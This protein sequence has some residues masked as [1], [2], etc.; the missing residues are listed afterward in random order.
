MPIS[1]IQFTFAPGG[2]FYPDDGFFENFRRELERLAP[3][4]RIQIVDPANWSADELAETSVFMGWPS[5]AML[6]AMPALRWIQLPSAGAD[7]YVGNPRLRDNVALTTAS[8]VFGVAGAEHALALLFA[9]ARGVHFHVA[10]TLENRWRMPESSFEIFES[11]IAVFGLGSIGSETAHRLSCLGAR[12]IGVRR[13]VT[14][15][16]PAYL[17]ELHPIGA[18]RAVVERSDAVVLAMPGTPET[19]GV[20]SREIIEAMRP[21]SILVNVG[22]G[23]AVDQDA[24]ID[25]LKTGRVRGAGL[26]VTDPEPLPPEHPLWSAPNVII[27]SHSMNVFDRKNERRFSLLTKNLELFARDEPLLNLVDHTRGY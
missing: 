23:T 14:S 6:D 13:T 16:V 10:N 4:S 5:D 7:R 1:P 26:D 27:A 3:G 21:G 11:T 9:V 18:A 19:A 24:L 20:F 22:R 8:G 17:A 12:V 2:D 15:T 25:A